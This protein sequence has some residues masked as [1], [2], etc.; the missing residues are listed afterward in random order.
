MLLIRH[1]NNNWCLSTLSIVK[2]MVSVC[3][4]CMTFVTAS[5]PGLK[6]HCCVGNI[7]F[8][9]FVMTIY[10]VRQCNWALDLPDIVAQGWSH[11][12]TEYHEALKSC[13]PKGKTEYY[14]WVLMQQALRAFI[15]NQ[16]IAAVTQDARTNQEKSGLSWQNQDVWQP[17]DQFCSYFQTWKLVTQLVNSNISESVIYHG[18]WCTDHLQMLLDSLQYLEILHTVCAVWTAAS[19]FF[20]HC[21]IPSM[22]IA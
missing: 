22:N 12:L 17:Y 1:G 2:D 21:P 19:T 4:V 14:R 11:S 18:K 9:I 3:M 8:L 20:F 13:H 16:D 10:I 5:T 7:T 6:N 15:K